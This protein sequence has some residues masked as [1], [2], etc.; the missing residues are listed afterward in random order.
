M[1]RKDDPL[2]LT[3]PQAS[4]QIRGPFRPDGTLFMPRL[5]RRERL[6]AY[7]RALTLTLPHAKPSRWDRAKKEKKP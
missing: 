6:A 1:P 2:S 7:A 4:V 5:S 3:P